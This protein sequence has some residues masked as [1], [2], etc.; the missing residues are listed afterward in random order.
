MKKIFV[1]LV[2][3]SILPLCAMEQEACGEANGDGAGSEAGV[4]HLKFSP[5][6]D[7]WELDTEDEDEEKKCGELFDRMYE[8][9]RKGRID[10]ARLK[11]LEDA[12]DESDAN[13]KKI[14]KIEKRIAADESLFGQLFSE[15]EEEDL[16]SEEEDSEGG[17]AT[18]FSGSEDSGSSSGEEDGSS[19]STEL[20]ELSSAD[21]EDSDAG[22]LSWATK[23]RD[24]VVVLPSA[25]QD[26]EVEP[27]DGD[28]P[29]DEDADERS[30]SSSD[31]AVEQE[32]EGSAGEPEVAA[33]A[34]AYEEA[35]GVI[36]DLDAPVD[37][38]DRARI[39]KQT[40]LA[41]RLGDLRKHDVDVTSLW[42]RLGRVETDLADLEREIDALGE[43]AGTAPADVGRGWLKRAVQSPV[44]GKVAGI[45]FGAFV[46]GGF[47]HRHVR[48][49]RAQGKPTIFDRMWSTSKEW[50]K[51]AERLVRRS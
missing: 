20:A 39:K 19:D 38:P 45:T 37:E 49:R 32:E 42:N 21:E 4:R 47:T 12:L 23:P 43:K 7:V 36:G 15:Q 50:K 28:A 1:L 30:G 34:D 26:A 17:R 22:F 25:A 24:G 9:R 18:D 41:G 29:V 2:L 8:L 51:K 40:E 11:Y 13:P 5:I 27:R 46:I 6:V 10:V 14:E 3:S 35:G 31:E 33:A 16:L 48:T 44:L